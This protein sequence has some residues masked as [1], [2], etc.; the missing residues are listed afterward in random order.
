MDVRIENYANSMGHHWYLWA[1]TILLS[2]NFQM[3]SVSITNCEC[4]LTDLKMDT[5]ENVIIDKMFAI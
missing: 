3:R 2:M 1:L 4:I 5:Q